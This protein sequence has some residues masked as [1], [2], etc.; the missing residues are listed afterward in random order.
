[1]SRTVFV[2]GEYLPES[3]ARISVFDRGLLFGDAVYE[4]CSVI[5]GQL[6]DNKSHL[7]RLQRSLDALGMAKPCS[8]ESLISIQRTLV[9]RNALNEG[10]IYL[11]VSRGV[12]DRDFYFPQGIEPSLVMFTQTKNLLN[13]DIESAALRVISLPDLR[14]GR[15]DIKTVG[16]L[17]PSMA[18]SEARAQGVQD[19]WLVDEQGFVTEAT[20]SNAFILT[21]DNQLI[22][23]N[24]SHDILH[25][26]TRQA[27]ITLAERSKIELVERPFTVAEACAAKEAFSTSASTFVMPVVEL[28]ASP[29]ADGRVG[30]VA[31]QL[32]RLY[33]ESAS[34]L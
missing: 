30:P 32:R 34:S 12:A 1:M 11:Q 26:I 29:I 27:V 13:V 22:T 2:N 8:E 25:G 5:N 9:D 28:D 16:L 14:W 17:Y 3:E 4:V 6:I 10:L 24:T 21:Q 33:I 23:R 31:R 7:A 19:A 15:R 18:K 20:S